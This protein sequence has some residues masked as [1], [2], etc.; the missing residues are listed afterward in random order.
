M[1]GAQAQ[2]QPA[3]ACSLTGSQ[4]TKAVRRQQDVC[5][6]RPGRAQCR[7]HSLYIASSRA[8]A[9]AADDADD[10][11]RVGS[12]ERQQG[13]DAERRSSTHK[14]QQGKGTRRS[15][16]A[17]SGEAQIVGRALAEHG[18]RPV[19]RRANAA[20][21]DPHPSP[22]RHPRCAAL[23]THSH[24]RAGQQRCRRPQA[25]VPLCAS[26]APGAPSHLLIHRSRRPCLCWLKERAAQDG[27]AAR[28]RISL[29][30]HVEG[31]RSVGSL[32]ATGSSWQQLACT[33]R[34][35]H[36]HTAPH[37]TSR[38]DRSRLPPRRLCPRLATISD[39]GRLPKPPAS[40]PL[41]PP[42][43]RRGVWA[44]EEGARKGVERGGSEPLRGAT[45]GEALRTGRKGCWSGGAAV[46][47]PLP[48]LPTLPHRPRLD[49]G[50]SR[51]ELLCSWCS[52]LAVRVCWRS[53]DASGELG[54]LPG[55]AGDSWRS[56]RTCEGGA[57]S[58]GCRSTRGARPRL[59]LAVRWGPRFSSP[60]GLCISRRRLEVGDRG[61]ERAA[62]ATRLSW[63]R[64]TAPHAAGSNAL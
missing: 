52:W 33:W 2:R 3:A 37:R 62:A 13:C 25:P 34:A 54:R 19:S 18:S 6:H 5:C 59:R 8:L 7:P 12:C 36:K 41:P 64:A 1:G 50:E 15:H 51:G 20:P 56:V 61:G 23:L 4:L 55:R 47:L 17:C 48:T 53:G 63:I 57:S 22:C 27:A 43:P 9:A 44:A 40:S 31:R 39:R 29:R 46:P 16:D 32:T 21:A 24:D 60:E 58:D 26:G 30:V 11:Q 38:G 10:E 28:S 45:S 49:E 14:A 35:A 42:P